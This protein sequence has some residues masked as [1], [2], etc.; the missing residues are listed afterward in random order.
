M[1]ERTENCAK[2]LSKLIVYCISGTPFRPLC[3][4]FQEEE[5]SRK[6]N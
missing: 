4:L 2:E 1:F 3:K 5:Y 6:I